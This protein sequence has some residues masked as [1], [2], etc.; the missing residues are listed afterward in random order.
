M[1]GTNFLE[2]IKKSII[3][4]STIAVLITSLVIGFVSIFPLYNMLMSKQKKY[5][6]YLLNMKALT[7]NEYISKLKN[8][9]IQIASRSKARESLEK[10]NNKKINL[11]EYIKYTKPILLDGKKLKDELVGIMRI[12]KSDSVVV[13]IGNF[14]FKTELPIPN[15]KTH[16]QLV[17][18]PVR[19]EGNSYF[20]V[21]S[22]ILNRQNERVGS[23]ICVYSIDELE[24]LLKN[25]MS[26]LQD[27]AETILGIPEDHKIKILDY[28]NNVED[29]YRE[30]G[31]GFGLGKVFEKTFNGESGI[32]NDSFEDDDKF[33]IAYAPVKKLNWGIL[34]KKDKQ[35][36][37]SGIQE[38][39]THMSILILFLV[40]LFVF[41]LILLLR[42]L[43]SKMLIHQDDLV[44]R[45]E[46]ATN[47][48]KDELNNHQKTEKKLFDSE[49]R[50]KAIVED[51]TEFICRF[52][53]DMTLTFANTAFCNYFVIN[54]DNVIGMKFNL[55]VAVE[56]KEKFFSHLR[57]LNKNNLSDTI[58][59]RLEMFNSITLWNQW[60]T[61]AIIDENN[62]IVE[63]QAVGY[64]ISARKKAEEELIA[65]NEEINRFAYMISHDMRAPLVNIDG[66]SSEINDTIIRAKEKTIKYIKDDDEY[67]KEFEYLFD[68]EI[69]ECFKYIKSSVDRMNDILDSILK[70]SRLGIRKLNLV[71]LNTKEI[72]ER[73]VESRAMLIKER[74]IHVD[75][76]ELPEITADRTYI[77][78]IFDN[79]ISNSIKYS[80]PKKDSFIKVFAETTL[81]ATTFYV[82]DNG[83]GISDENRNKVFEL[84]RQAGNHDDKGIGM[85]LTY[86]RTMV[87][88][89]GGKIM[90]ESSF[91]KG[92]VFSFTLPKE[93]NVFNVGDYYNNDY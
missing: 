87:R 6:L 43:T 83:I 84:F 73:I 56:D 65:A 7:V 61:R 2:K 14:K 54:P 64:D 63:Y 91:G 62:D 76:N 3:L 48:F 92:T 69:P 86:V 47:A 90:F 10:Y 42:P 37:Y 80:D 41:L 21:G 79:L 57:S 38:Q 12:D 28:S 60:T 67:R 50:Y 13:N 36:L 71:N 11:E 20:L 16:K 72:V 32:F 74:N 85:G 26:I 23:D 30:I 53:P 78:H 22:P 45:I 52:S 33:C 70:L 82:E 34:I 39:I 68:I 4:Y 89:L 25:W 75:I 46:E 49:K 59:I 8:I 93:I 58:E 51:Q 55:P 5:M 24:K 44:F 66:F 18:G 17:K 15:K 19:Y 31:Y 81:K 9:S 35:V 29:I 88:R 1:S 77:E 40:G 27:N